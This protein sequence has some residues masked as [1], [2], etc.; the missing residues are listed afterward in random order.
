MTT[1]VIAAL[2]IGWAFNRLHNQTGYR[3]PACGSRR[4]DGHARECPWSSRA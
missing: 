1:V 2:L 3:C 4:P